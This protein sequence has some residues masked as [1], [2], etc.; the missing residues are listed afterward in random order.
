MAGGIGSRFWPLSRTA[1]PKQFHDILGTGETLLQATFRR[2]EAIIGAERILVVTHQQYVHLVSEQLP[3]LPPANMLAEPMARNTAACIA[4]ALYRILPADPQAVVAVC[5]ADHA[6]SNEEEYVN[7][8]TK[9]LQVGYDKQSV[10]TLGIEP[11][12]PDTGYGYIQYLDTP[13]PDYWRVKLFTEKP[14]LEM[15][16]T[17]L[18]SGDFVWN[19]GMFFFSAAVMKR[20]LRTF[21]PDLVELFDSIQDQLGTVAEAKAIEKIYA[22]CPSI[23]ID[24]AVME[25]AEEVYMLRGNFG[26]SD[27]GTWASLYEMLP[28]DDRRNV[29]SGEI[30]PY[31]ADGNMVYTTDGK[32]V[33]LK[34]VKNLIVVETEDALLICPKDQEQEIRDVVQDLKNGKREQYL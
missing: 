29:L 22:R 24:Y 30:I 8:I 31:E 9:A 16:Q 32:L 5:P 28:K 33:I 15:A 13:G 12:R 2:L 1:F 10:V 3:Q 4:Y 19:S 26:W 25:K 34:G 7:V 11:T 23:S 20:E 17:F 18:S 14:N 27:L 6:I 21:L